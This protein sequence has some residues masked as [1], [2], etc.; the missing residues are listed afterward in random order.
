MKVKR[1]MRGNRDTLVT[2]LVDLNGAR[3][4]INGRRRSEPAEVLRAHLDMNSI[5]VQACYLFS[6][7]TIFLIK[8]VVKVYRSG[9]LTDTLH[10]KCVASV[11]DIE[12]SSVDILEI[13]HLVSLRKDPR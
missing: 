11:A 5:V 6:M 12:Y 7:F 2:P 10:R 13:L 4:L 8:T 3:W 9:A 1:T